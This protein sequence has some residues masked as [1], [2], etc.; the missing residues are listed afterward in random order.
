MRKGKDTNF[1]KVSALVV[2]V[3]ALAVAVAGCFCLFD[4]SYAAGIG[5]GSSVAARMCHPLFHAGVVHAVVNVY[6]LWQLVFFFPLRMRHLLLAY[7]VA[8]LCSTLQVTSFTMWP[9][10]ASGW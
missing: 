9:R 5:D 1:A 4:E 2:G 6:V 10:K 8:C 3:V 7:T